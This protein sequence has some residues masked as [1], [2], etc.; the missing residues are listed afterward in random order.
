M[1]NGWYSVFD[2]KFS[3]YIN[4]K[5]PEYLFKKYFIHFFTY[6]VS[7]EIEQEFD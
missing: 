2:K 1:N 7:H 5:E 6:D 3:S 4:Y